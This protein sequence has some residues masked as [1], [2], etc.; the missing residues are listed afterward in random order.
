M[1]SHRGFDRRYRATAGCSPLQWLLHQRVL[2]AQQILATTTLPIDTVARASGFTPL[3]RRPP[4]SYRTTFRTT[5]PAKSARQ[6]ASII[7]R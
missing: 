4:Q 6:M 7:P 2:R 1:A 3:R 5:E